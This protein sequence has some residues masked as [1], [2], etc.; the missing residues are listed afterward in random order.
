MTFAEHIQRQNKYFGED[1]TMYWNATRFLWRVFMH[2]KNAR[3]SMSPPPLRA[4]AAMSDR[5]RVPSFR[6]HVLR[7]QRAK[8]QARARRAALHV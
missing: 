8:E 5:A 7:A 4:Y 2:P 1:I 3:R 6:A